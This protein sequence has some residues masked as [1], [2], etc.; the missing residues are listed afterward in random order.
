MAAWEYAIPGWNTYKIANDVAGRDTSGDGQKIKDWL[1]GG[2]A[3]QGM[4]SGPQTADY[5]RGYL[6]QFNNRQAPMMNA[7]QSNQVRGQQGQLASML[8]Q[9]AAGNQ[10]GAGEMA[11]RRQI[12]AGMAQN[13]SAAQMAR[14]AN[15][16]LA[17]RN[18]A[19]ANSDLSVNGAGQAA[20]AQLNDRNAAQG[21]LAGLLGQTRQ[22]DIGVAQGNQSAQMQ[23]QQLQ[24]NA[25]AQML[26][27]DVAALQQDLAKRGLKMQDQGMLPGLL[28]VG[29][30][31]GAAAAGGA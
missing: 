27:V 14:G 22:Q 30:Q 5:Q 1:L 19:R 8:F 9:T 12:G 7:S 10:P 17:A 20:I 21:Q 18:A 11:V 28:Q 25:L 29:G 6:Q 31:I 4:A 16:A 23:Q 24:L 26:G 2:Q 15:S 3:T 13:T